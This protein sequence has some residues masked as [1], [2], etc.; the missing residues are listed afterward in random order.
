MSIGQMNAIKH[1][2]SCM[3]AIKFGGHAESGIGKKQIM[4]IAKC[5]C[6]KIEKVRCPRFLAGAIF[7]CFHFK[8][9]PGKSI[10][11]RKNQTS[12]KIY[13]CYRNM[14]QRCYNKQHPK[15]RFYGA[16]GVSVC[17]SWRDN[18][19]NF[20]KWALDNGWEPGLQIDKDTIGNGKLYSPKTCCFLSRI[21]N[22]RTKKTGSFKMYF[23][24]GK[25]RSL[26]SICL[27]E[28]A[29]YPTVCARIRLLGLSLKESLT[30]KK[31]CKTKL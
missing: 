16:K 8:K 2:E 31:K 24:K 9:K 25:E 14:I 19:D 5:S 4:I 3:T 27:M 11:R 28:K 6:G 21:D 13:E 29:I 26:K 17:K 10:L 18:Y 30:Y 15:Y 20:K 1:P 12:I 22:N 7:N 23:W